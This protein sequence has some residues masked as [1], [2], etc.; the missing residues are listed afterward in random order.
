[1]I[2]LVAIK[3]VGLGVIGHEQIRPAIMIVVQQCNSQRFRTAVE[4]SARRGHVFKSTVALIVE[5]PAGGAA[6]GFGSAVR[7][8]LSIKAAEH[9]VF[10]RPLH[11]VADKEI[12]PSVPVV[13]EPQ[14]GCAKTLALSQS[15]SIRYIN[16]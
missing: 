4:N 12:E 11:I 2:L 7:F 6:I 8:V 1:A 9:I 5:E 13:I 14:G 3:L 16:K 15:T 10:R